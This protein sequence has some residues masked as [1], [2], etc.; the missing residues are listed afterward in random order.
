MIAA[1]SIRF[2][3]AAL[4]AATVLT[5]S[6]FMSA[7][8]HAQVTPFMQAVAQAAS[9][10]EGI[11]AFYRTNGYKPIWTGTGPQDIARRTALLNA[12]QQAGDHA[13]PV[14]SYNIER[15]SAKL[16]RIDSERDL[17]LAEVEM[18]RVFLKYARDIQTGVLSP[19]NVDDDIVRDIPLRDRT[20]LLEEF[21]VAM[22]AAFLR[23]LPPQAPE[24]SRLMKAKVLLEKQME[25]GGWGPQVPSSS[26]KPGDD[27]NAV[28]MLRNRMIAMGYMG[29]SAASSYDTALQEAVRLFQEDH[30]LEPDGVAGRDTLTAI[31]VQIED[32][33]PNIIVAME[34]ER[35]MNIPRGKRHVW[36][37]LT[38]FRTRLIENDQVIFETKSVI[39][40]NAYH[41]RSPEFS[42]LMEYMVINPNWYVPNTIAK[43]EYLPKILAN[44]AAAGYL[45]LIDRR[46]QV[47]NRSSV[48][49]SRYNVNN[50]PYN[51]RQPPG[52]RNALGYVK[53]MFPNPYNIYLHDTPAKNLFQANKRDFSWGCIRLNDPFDFAYALLEPQE[54]DPVAYFQERLKS[55]EN[56]RVALKQPV[57]VHLVYRTAYTS[58]KGRLNFR[59]DIYERDAKIF[60]ALIQAGVALRAYRS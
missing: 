37:N 25:R 29:R 14:A 54:A 52:G 46:G 20:K 47:V 18:S 26:L 3:R 45:Q 58:T 43:A 41:R 15:L 22:P 2:G 12:L 17:G 44:P 31:N 50:F 57:P 7:P 36:V 24:Y 60:D 28:A 39:G 35:W 23:D 33:L 32:R 59:D 55:G 38:D 53:F 5:L 1:C 48:N 51:L 40:K 9:G 11:A 34:R 27:G 13:L 56:T 16:S 19:K 6:A 10:D 49:F 21:S 30:G 4:T 8:A 42:D